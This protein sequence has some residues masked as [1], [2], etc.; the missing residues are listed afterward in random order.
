MKGSEQKCPNWHFVFFLFFL[1]F[2]YLCSKVADFLHVTQ[3][4]VE[5]KCSIIFLAGLFFIS[6]N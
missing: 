4:Y 6:K 2:F 1:F 3:D 5:N